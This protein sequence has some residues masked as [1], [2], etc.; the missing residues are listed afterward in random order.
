MRPS[1]HAPR[2]TTDAHEG[3]GG[4]GGK[5]HGS[6]GASPLSADEGCCTTSQKL[7]CL[8]RQRGQ[9]DTACSALQKGSHVANATSPLLPTYLPRNGS[10]GTATAGGGGLAT[11][12]PP[13]GRAMPPQNEHRLQRQSEQ[14]S[15]ARLCVQKASH[16][17]ILESVLSRGVQAALAEQKPQ[18]LQSH[19]VQWAE[20]CRSRQKLLQPSTLPS[21]LAAGLHALLA[22][23]T[24]AANDDEDEEEEEGDEEEGDARFGVGDADAPCE[25]PQKRHALHAQ[26]EQCT[27]RCS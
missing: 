7:H 13:P 15:D 16:A 20:A 11:E 21:S 8:Q 4:G 27:P 22:P 12:L 2:L 3:S 26:A 1:A 19:R 10:Q 24:I 14:W 18:A 6:C 9:W 23:P 25:P 17:S 5:R